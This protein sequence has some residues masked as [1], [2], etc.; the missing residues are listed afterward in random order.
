M[1]KLLFV[2]QLVFFI[3]LLYLADYAVILTSPYFL[4]FLIII[5]IAAAISYTSLSVELYSPFPEPVKNHK[6]ITKGSYS[7]IR[8]PMYT[9]Y[10]LAALLLT[11]SNFVVRAEVAF[12]LFLIIL[13]VTA[14]FEEAQIAK[15]DEAYREYQKVTRKFIPFLY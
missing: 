7:Y 1:A 13:E 11:L 9:V 14:D 15:K 6:L 10:A 8:H 12:V 3:T 4:V 5:V 2:L